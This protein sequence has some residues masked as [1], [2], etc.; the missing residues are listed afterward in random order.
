MPVDLGNMAV[1]NVTHRFA[2]KARP[3]GTYFKK[4]NC[5]NAI[6]HRFQKT[7][8]PVRSRILKLKIARLVVGSE[9]TSESRVLIVF[10][11]FAR[12]GVSE[13]DSS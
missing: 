9:T 2:K 5:L 12:G 10:V 4:Q 8:V 6:G 7:G 11:L 1:A 13:V 3:G